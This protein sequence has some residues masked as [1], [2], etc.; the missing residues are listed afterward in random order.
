MRHLLINSLTFLLMILM[1]SYS[2][3]ETN[4]A[5]VESAKPIQAKPINTAPVKVII[6]TTKGDITL[7]L[8][9]EKAPVSVENFLTYIASGH[10]K[11]TVFHR[12][13]R[14]FMIQGGG[15]D[16]DMIRKATLPAIENEAK[17]GLLNARGT[18]AMARTSDINSA[19]SQFFINVKN[20]KFLNHGFRDYGYAV[21]GKVIAGMDVV[22]AIANVATG[23]Q[24]VPVE[25][26]II[27]EVQ[28][29]KEKASPKP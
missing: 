22:D 24:D 20:N 7:E 21:F 9:R 5:K 16:E 27:K 12:V 17:N 28:L 2:Q 4:T 23:Q 10:Y 11:G 13:I 26:V 1:N 19:T 14:N 3:A 15:F 18:I 25:P 6:S 29:L 8:N